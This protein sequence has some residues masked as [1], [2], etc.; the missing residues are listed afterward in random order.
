MP[1]VQGH[2]EHIL[3]KRHTSLPSTPGT[4]HSREQRAEDILECSF[5]LDTDF[6]FVT[7][8]AYVCLFSLNIQAFGALQLPELMKSAYLAQRVPR[9]EF[10]ND[11][12]L[13]SYRRQPVKK[14]K[15]QH[16]IWHSPVSQKIV[17]HSIFCEF[18][19]I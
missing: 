18:F 10:Q 9:C 12:V 11:T 19:K 5:K 3:H 14:Q 17:T 4:E 13:I 8:L 6:H 2:C 1:K 7:F 15:Q 16:V